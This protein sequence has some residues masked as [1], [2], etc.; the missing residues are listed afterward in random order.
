MF[1]M[2]WNG[3]VERFMFMD[4]S[5]TQ[6]LKH[7]AL[8]WTFGE[9]GTLIREKVC[10]G[11]ANFIFLLLKSLGVHGLKRMSWEI[12]RMFI[13]VWICCVERLFMFTD[14]VYMVR[15]PISQTSGVRFYLRWIWNADSWVSLVPAT[16]SLCFWVE[17]SRSS[18]IETYELRDLGNVMISIYYSWSRYC[19]FLSE[20]RECIA[21]ES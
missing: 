2:V 21:P 19:V 20:T 13:M 15:H 6:S 18:R 11:D 16:P 7:L 5:S 12:Y 17:I 4:N 14:C 3:C 10:A 9:Y 8:H 1:I